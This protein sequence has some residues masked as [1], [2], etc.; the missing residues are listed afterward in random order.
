MR[1]ERED[2]GRNYAAAKVKLAHHVTGTW[3]GE[4]KGK[5][6]FRTGEPKILEVDREELQCTAAQR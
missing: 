5:L 2:L 3:R 1:K 6:V 4:P